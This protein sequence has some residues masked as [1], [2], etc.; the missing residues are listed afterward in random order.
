MRCQTIC[1][2]SFRDEFFKG[3]KSGDW[4]AAHQRLK[5]TVGKLL[6]SYVN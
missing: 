3:F 6:T 5:L 1:G 2:K 4:Q